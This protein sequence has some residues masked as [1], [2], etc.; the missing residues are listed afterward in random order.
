MTGRWEYF[1]DQYGVV[2]RL[3]VDR[4]SEVDAFLR[5][6]FGT[7]KQEPTETKDGGK[8]GWFPTKEIGVAIQFGYDR[9]HAQVIVLR[10][11][12]ASEIIKRLPEAMERSQ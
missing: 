3:P 7:P 11:Q 9:E 10:P 2:V 5:A 6:A 8:L 4:F 12:P 1:Q